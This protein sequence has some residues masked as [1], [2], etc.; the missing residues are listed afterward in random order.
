[1][2][3]KSL[4][5]VGLASLLLVSPL[6][7]AQAFTISIDSGHG[8]NGSTAGKRFLDGTRYEWDINDAVADRLQ[9]L[10]EKHGVTVHRLDDASGQ[11]DVSLNSRLQQAIN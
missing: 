5:N 11:T 8:G 7:E 2:K 4:A 10:L 9:P 3:T 6:L 1:M